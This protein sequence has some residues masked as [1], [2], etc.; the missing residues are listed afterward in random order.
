MGGGEQ[1]WAGVKGRG[2]RGGTVQPGRWGMDGEV[3]PEGLPPPQNG[4]HWDVVG[5]RGAGGGQGGQGCGQGVGGHGGYGWVG[6]GD[7][8][9]VGEWVGLGGGWVGVGGW[10]WVGRGG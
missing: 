6:M 7:G 5:G 8:W 2:K 1:G 4:L 9:V 10:V 3:R